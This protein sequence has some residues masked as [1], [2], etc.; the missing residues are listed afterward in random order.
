MVMTTFMVSMGDLLLKAEHSDQDPA[1]I[2][3]WPNHAASGP[4]WKMRIQDERDFVQGV[5]EVPPCESRVWS[6]GLDF[7]SWEGGPAGCS[8]VTEGELLLEGGT[9]S[10]SG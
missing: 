1:I 9:P 8:S 4:D 6:A 7:P 3:G 5:A 10:R 2:L